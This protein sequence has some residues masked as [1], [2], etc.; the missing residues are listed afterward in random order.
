MT[1]T[2]RMWI[3]SVWTTM[4]SDSK[5]ITFTAHNDSRDGNGSL[6]IEIVSP[7]T[8]EDLEK[9]KSFGRTIIIDSEEKFN[10]LFY[11]L[12]EMDE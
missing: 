6:S 4:L 7:W 3:N 9:K 2:F 11:A 8:S 5:I 10:F 1:D 12:K